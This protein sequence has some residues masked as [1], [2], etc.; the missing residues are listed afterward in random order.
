MYF[1]ENQPDADSINFNL[2]TAGGFEAPQFQYDLIFKL[3]IR[4]GYEL[5]QNSYGY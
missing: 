3:W 5:T 4:D 1:N 2:S